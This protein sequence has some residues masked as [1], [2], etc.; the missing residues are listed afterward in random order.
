MKYKDKKKEVKEV[1]PEVAEV[2]ETET[3]SIPTD[4]TWI[5]PTPTIV[6]DNPN[7]N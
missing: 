6:R 3:S 7:D 4:I 5:K 2:A 1:V